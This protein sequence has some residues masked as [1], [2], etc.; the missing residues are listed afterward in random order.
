MN[1]VDRQIA[2][3]V[4]QIINNIFKKDLMK[5]TKEDNNELINLNIE[6]RRKINQ[7]DIKINTLLNYLG[8]DYDDGRS[9]LPKIIKKE[10]SNG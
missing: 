6:L 10:K 5:R 7:I 4:L 1:V 8:L 9:T 2:N 3:D